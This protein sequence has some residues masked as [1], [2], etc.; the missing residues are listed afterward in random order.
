MVVLFVVNPWCS[1]PAVAE[2][3]DFDNLQIASTSYGRVAGGGGGLGGSRLMAAYNNDIYF[4]VMQDGTATPSKVYRYDPSDGWSNSANHSIVRET[5]GKFV[6]LRKIDGL[7]YFS[8]NL[9]NVYFYDGTTPTEM[10]ETPFTASDY[11][12]SSI[13][14]F[15]GLMYFATSAG[16]IF[17]YNEGAFE[18]VDD[19][20]EDR[21]IIDMVPWQKDGYLYVSVGPSKACCPPTGYLIRS[22]TGDRGSWEIVFSGFRDIWQILPTPDYLYAGVLDTSY[23]HSSTVRKSSNG[24]D[25]PIIYGP[26]GQYKRA[27]GSFYYDGIAYIFADDRSGG[28]G[29]IIVDENGSVNCIPNQNWTLTQAVELNGEVYALASSP[30]G[31]LPGDVYLITTAAEPAAVEIEWVTIGNAGNAADTV[32][33][34]DGTTGYGAVG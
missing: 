14:E 18:Q 6:T 22:S 24:T 28:L 12:S 19:I 25:F 32:V 4:I 23:S 17:R 16:N 13:V 2:P 20:G 3:I 1:E 11:V 34:N 5:T 8:D 30:P 26:D 15:N 33:M 31:E 7:L 9:G 10:L 27:W 29:E 21:L